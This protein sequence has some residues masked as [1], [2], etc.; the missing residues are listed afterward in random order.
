M[1]NLLILH[2]ESISRQ[3]FE[4]FASAFP[5]T[6][7]LMA[8]ALVFDNYVSSATSTMMV[9]T[10]LWHGND[11]EFDAA[12]EFEGMRPARNNPNLFSVLRDH[13]YR[14]GLIGLNAFHTL[15]PTRL[16]AWPDDLPPVWGTNDFPTLHA[17]FD[18]LTDDGPFALYVWDLVTH[19]EHSQALSPFA[20]GLTDQLQRACAVADEAIGECLATLER[21]GLLANTTIVVYGDHGDDYW[22]HGFRGGLVHGT[23]PYADITSAPL[24][25]RDPGLPAGVYSGLASTIDLRATCL[26]LLGIDGGMSFAPSGIDLLGGVNDV[27]FAQNFT[28]NQPDW[29]ARGIAKTFAATDGTYTLLA[30]S[31]GLELYANRLDPG[32]HC[33]LLQFFTLAPGG[34]L[35]LRNLVNASMHFRAALADNR[36]NLDHLESGF[37]RLRDALAT[38]V[39]AKRAFIEAQGAAATH[40]LDPKCLDRIGR[41]GCEVAG[42]GAPVTASPPTTHVA[43]DFSVKLR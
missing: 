5:R 17:K 10:Y 40:A 7:A 39:A 11:F 27:V 18:A 9:L 19:V 25:I 30:N 13:G 38:R 32:N 8:D 2:L 14:T 41:R 16:S 6:R 29:P 34:G 22:T 15:Q 36:R 26:G 1:K 12:T 20:N 23:E 28:A 43:F 24:A 33:N 35:L 4:C 3:R 42:A 37:R 21:K 31:G